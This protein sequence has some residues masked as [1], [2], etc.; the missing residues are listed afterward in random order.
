M[1]NFGLGILPGVI[2]LRKFAKLPR[3]RGLRAFSWVWNFL[4]R[5][6]LV[7][8]RHPRISLHSSPEAPLPQWILGCQG[9]PPVLLLAVL[10]LLPALLTCCAFKSLQVVPICLRFRLRSVL[11][12]SCSACPSTS[13]LLLSRT[14]QQH[15]DYDPYR[16]RFLMRLGVLGVCSLMPCKV[17]IMLINMHSSWCSRR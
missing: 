11:I 14:Y 4:R 7:V 6:F 13:I 5:F 16:L 1:V 17:L 2:F 3:C 9:V 15:P 10:L 8:E 12:S